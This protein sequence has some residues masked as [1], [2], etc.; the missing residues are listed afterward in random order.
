MDWSA[1]TG[2]GIGQGVAVGCR[3]RNGAGHRFVFRA[4]DGGGC[5]QGDA[6]VLDR[7]S[8]GFGFAGAVIICHHDLEAVGAGVAGLGG[9]GEVAV[10]V[11]AHAAVGRPIRTVDGVGQ[12]VAGG[13][14]GRNRTGHRLVF[15]AGDGG[16]R[17][18]G[19]TGI[20]DGYCHR[21]GG[22]GAVGISGEDVE[23]VGPGETGA[24]GVNEIARSVDGGLAVLGIAGNAESNRVPDRWN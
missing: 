7:H 17:G 4:G 10:G 5:R 1:R 14:G 19:H 18:Q 13:S 21:A 12:G 6:G 15:R 11:D 2:N 23:T 22:G 8:H 24:G 3:C 9:V 20:L 16:A